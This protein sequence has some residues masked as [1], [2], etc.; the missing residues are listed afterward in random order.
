ME[1]VR[2][3]LMKARYIVLSCT[4]GKGQACCN[5]RCNGVQRG[6]TCAPVALVPARARAQDDNYHALPSTGNLWRS[7][8]ATASLLWGKTKRENGL[9]RG[10]GTEKG[11]GQGERER[12]ERKEREK[13]KNAPVLTSRHGTP[14][15]RAIRSLH[16]HGDFRNT[17]FLLGPY[18]ILHR[19]HL[20]PLLALCNV[21]LAG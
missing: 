3:W 10:R 14:R 4:R 1:C 16:R 7:T 5:G 20:V 11:R 13:K 2:I 9:K 15:I 18:L 6:S 19:C 12:E 8:R 17:R 21:N